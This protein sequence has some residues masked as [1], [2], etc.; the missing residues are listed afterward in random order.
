MAGAHAVQMVSA[1]LQSGPGHL[2][3][4]RDGLALWLEEHGY[5]SLTELRGSMSLLR[6]TDP[7]TYE[8][9]NYVKVLQSWHDWRS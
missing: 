7:W 1:L 5:N 8:R 3:R 4:V 2:G 9:A 6:C